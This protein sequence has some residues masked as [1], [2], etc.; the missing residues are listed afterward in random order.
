MS[1]YG[2][3][4]PHIVRCD[5]FPV[6]N[7]MCIMAQ[8][9]LAGGVVGLEGGGN[10]SFNSSPPQPVEHYPDG[11]PK[12]TGLIPS[13]TQGGGVGGK[14]GEESHKKRRKSKKNRKVVSTTSTSSPLVLLSQDLTSSTTTSPH[15]VHHHLQTMTEQQETSKDSPPVVEES[16][17]IHHYPSTMVVSSNENKVDV[18]DRILSGYC[19]S[20]WSLKV[21]ATARGNPDGSITLHVKSYRVL[22]GGSQTSDMRPSLITIPANVT[23]E[24]TSS[25][26]TSSASDIKTV[27]AMTM[28]KDQDKSRFYVMGNTRGHLY[29][30]NFAIPWPHKSPHFRLVQ[31]FLLVSILLIQ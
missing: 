21:R 12:G 26:R 8:H 10:S 5:Q 3:P 14:K 7:D 6:D 25:S 28:A 27:H 1:K 16:G 20:D 18:Q 17:L 19:H 31:T 23:Q 15:R 29:L 13:Q 4:W 11:T 22:W 9:G 30:A 24:I 2:Y